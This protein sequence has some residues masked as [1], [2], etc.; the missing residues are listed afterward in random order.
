MKKIKPLAWMLIAIVMLCSNA[1][2][3]F[4]AAEN[5]QV[6]EDRKSVV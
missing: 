3:I 6:T 4:A 5:I 1:V 2:T